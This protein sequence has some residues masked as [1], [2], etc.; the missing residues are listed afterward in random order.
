MDSDS[1]ESTS[2]AVHDGCEALFQRAKLVRERGLEL[3]AELQLRR[4]RTHE[5]VATCQRLAKSVAS[6]CGTTISG[7][8]KIRGPNK[9]RPKNGDR[10]KRAVV[11]HLLE[12]P[13]VG[14]AST[15]NPMHDK[16]VISAQLF[17][18]PAGGRNKAVP[19]L[20]RNPPALAPF[21]RDPC[22]D[23]NVLS[24]LR[25]RAPER[26]HV[27][28]RRLHMSLIALDK[29]SSQVA[30]HGP[31]TRSHM[32]RTMCPMGKA[33][34]PAQFKRDFC[35]RL[36]A[37]RVVAGLDQAD[38]AKRLGLL[39]NT[40][41][42]YERR[43]LLPHYLVAQAAAILGV[44]E[45]YLFTGD[46]MVGRQRVGGSVTSEELPRARDRA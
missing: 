20:G 12:R 30:T 5:L 28:D 24:H 44:D 23:S 8:G 22:G 15:P 9:K 36:A 27:V 42:K 10:R 13:R 11:K 34:T 1:G 14:A 39:P 38:F 25:D 2:G 33:S 7:G 35:K 21:L 29:Q 17:A 31:V 26:K 43:S 18:F 19:V 16:K 32:D 40:Y 6:V 3:Q 37:A 46:G 41:S 4:A 45:H